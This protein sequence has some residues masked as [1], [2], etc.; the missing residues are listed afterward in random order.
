MICLWVSDSLMPT[1]LR[2]LAFRDINA[3]PVAFP[4]SVVAKRQEEATGVCQERKTLASVPLSM[5]AAFRPV[6]RVEPRFG[7]RRMGDAVG[8]D[9]SDGVGACVHIGRSFKNPR[10]VT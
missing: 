3:T 2:V 7:H 6:W 1:A 10:Q 5:H 4:R 8:D 9:R